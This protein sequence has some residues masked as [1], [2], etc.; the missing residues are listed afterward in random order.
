MLS[1]ASDRLVCQVRIF[2]QNSAPSKNHHLRKSE[3]SPAGYPLIL[4]EP[5]MNIH[6]IIPLWIT[7][8]ENSVENVENYELSTV[9]P[10]F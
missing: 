4:C 6:S 3:E 2:A 8:V 7:L 5:K 9:I 1:A 10:L